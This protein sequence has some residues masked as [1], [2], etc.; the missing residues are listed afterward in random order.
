MNENT[1][2]RPGTAKITLDVT[3]LNLNCKL[4]HRVF[5]RSEDDVLHCETFYCGST[6]PKCGEA[7]H[8]NLT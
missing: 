2:G 4:T 7:P 8:R 1:N 5:A 6:V 3:A